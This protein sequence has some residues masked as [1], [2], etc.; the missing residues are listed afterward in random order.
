MISISSYGQFSKLIHRRA[1]NRKVIVCSDSNIDMHDMTGFPPPH[2]S[3]QS[4]L[5]VEFAAMNTVQTAIITSPD[6][7]GIS[8]NTC[9]MTKTKNPPRPFFSNYNCLSSHIF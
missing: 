4:P 9:Y 7:E 5:Y 6:N 1:S 2:L 8:H 3:V